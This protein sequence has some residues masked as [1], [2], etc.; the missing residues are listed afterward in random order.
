MGNTGEY[1]QI[2]KLDGNVWTLV[3]DACDRASLVDYVQVL[4]SS[5]NIDERTPLKSLAGLIAPAYTL[6]SRSREITPCR[7]RAYTILK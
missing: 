7:G 1:Y 6:S 5:E 3:F 2:G 4:S